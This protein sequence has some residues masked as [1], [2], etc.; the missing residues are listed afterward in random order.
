MND[1]KMNIFIILVLIAVLACM[2]WA[3]LIENR[4]SNKGV[5]IRIDDCA[6]VNC[7]PQGKRLG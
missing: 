3:K 7:L 6:Y 1:R 2:S 4:L 5:K